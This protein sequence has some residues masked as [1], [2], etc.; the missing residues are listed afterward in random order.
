MSCVLAGLVIMVLMAIMMWPRTAL[1]AGLSDETFQRIIVL[2]AAVGVGYV[3]THLAVERLARRF[4]FAGGIEYI[5]LG[6]V[7]GPLLG[8]LDDE[9][10]RDIRPVLLL[11]AGALGMLAGLELGE[12]DAEARVRG[13]WAAALSI[14]SFTALTIIAL[15]LLIAW[16]LGYS[17][18]G[19][20]AWT[21]ALL[22][23]GV[24]ALGSDGALIGSLAHTLGARGPAPA[25]GIAVANR[26]RA[27][28][29]LGFGLLYALINDTTILDTRPLAG[30]GLALGLQV[31]AGI[32]LGLLFGVVIHRKLDER[33][34]LTVVVGMVFL[35]GGFAYAMDVSG[36]FVNFIAGLTFARTSPHAGEATRTMRSIKQP[37][38]I[39]LY[40]FAGLEWV[41][42]QVWVYAMILPFLAVRWVGRYLGGALAARFGGVPANLG[43]ATA[44]PGGLTLAF[45][46]SIGLV[47]RQAPGIVDA[48]GPLVTALVLLELHSVR[49]VRRWLADTAGIT[50]EVSNSPAE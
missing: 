16:A 22:F 50:T 28:A 15:P 24:V 42:G 36:I 7:L 38:V 8:L 31:G 33:T 32:V 29:V 11:G 23:A 25:I 44:A 48:Y 39:A 17:I 45:V 21:G 19:D 3:I 37:F 26:V 34:L 6:I 47:Y 1:A 14:T 13:A 2:L 41:G 40:F 18:D 4:S 35:G 10:I 43:P 12:R 9:L 20:H 27:V 46:L 30:A 5:A 49:A